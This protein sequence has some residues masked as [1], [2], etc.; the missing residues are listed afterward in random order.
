MCCGCAVLYE[1]GSAEFLPPYNLT[2]APDAAPADAACRIRLL[3][4]GDRVLAHH[5]VQMA[6]A[7]DGEPVRYASVMLPLPPEPV[8]A[9]ALVCGGQRRRAPASLQ[10]L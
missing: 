7:A 8:Q 9:M 5:P 1:D 6:E 4:D 10:S 2:G 3:G